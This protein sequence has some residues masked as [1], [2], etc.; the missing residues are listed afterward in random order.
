VKDVVIY[1]KEG[2]ISKIVL[3]RPQERNAL[4]LKTLKKLIDAFE[5]SEENKDLCVVFIAEGKDFSVGADL[6]YG[7]SLMNRPDALQESIEYGKSI[8]E[9]TRAMR[10]HGGIIIGGLKGYVIG[11]AFE[12]TLSCD[13]RVATKDAIIMMPELNLGTMFSNASTK[14]LPNLM[15]ETKTKQLLLLEDRI[16]AEEAHRMGLVNYIVEPEDLMKELDRIVQ[17][18]SEKEPLA[19]R[20]AKKLI[21][22]NQDAD[23]NTALETE[24]SAMI[25]CNSSQ[26]FRERLKAFIE[27]RKP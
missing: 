10:N 14:L 6:K 23:I 4:D 22:E 15:G 9:L 20:L 26:G 17:K 21:N 25:T 8:Q 7:Y 1:E 3:N 2:A 16:T 19:L 11:G 24:L 12:I 13:L 27:K 18:I 5:E